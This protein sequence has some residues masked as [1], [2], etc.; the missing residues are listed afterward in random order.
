MGLEAF[1][2][3]KIVLHYRPNNFKKGQRSRTRR[4]TLLGT[5][6][7]RGIPREH[8][9][10]GSP[11]TLMGVE[12][13]YPSDGFSNSQPKEDNQSMQKFGPCGTCRLVGFRLI[14]HWVAP[15]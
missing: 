13:V 11:I 12:Q 1:I 3:P 2:S 8:P 7:V 5:V 10:D 6:S 14:R 9:R 15:A 4:K